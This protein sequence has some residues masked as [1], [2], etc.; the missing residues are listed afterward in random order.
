MI[1]KGSCRKSGRD[2]RRP[3][4]W[5]WEKEPSLEK[6]VLHAILSIIASRY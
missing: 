4:R 5:S 1:V 2:D 3:Q 6:A